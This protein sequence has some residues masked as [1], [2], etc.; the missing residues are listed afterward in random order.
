MMKIMTWNTAL[1][2]GS[3]AQAVINYVKPF[4]D[5]DNAV[6]VLQQIPYKDP[7][8][9]WTIFPTHAYF[10]A[11]FPENEY[12]IIQNTNHNNGFTRMFQNYQRFRISR[13]QTESALCV[14]VITTSFWGFTFTA[15]K[16][17]QMSFGP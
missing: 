13:Q 1:S 15:I 2:E 6:A 17:M 16:G 8:N 3:N 5:Q 11:A 4:I 14:L 10:M 7:D 9:N 12:T